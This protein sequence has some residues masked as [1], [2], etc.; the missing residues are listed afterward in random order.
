MFKKFEIFSMHNPFKINSLKIFLGLLEY[1]VILKLAMMDDLSAN[2][3][4]IKCKL[5]SIL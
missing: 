3:P 2:V 5:C 1:A 4:A